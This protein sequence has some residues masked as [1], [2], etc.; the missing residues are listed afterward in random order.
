MSSK[1][2]LD[3]L[4]Q[5]GMLPDAVI[6]KL[7]R[8]LSE[9][10]KATTPDVVARMLVQ[11]GLLTVFQAK[12][13]L[14]EIQKQVGRKPAG[15]QPQPTKS[16]K[17]KKKA[18]ADSDDLGLAAI[19]DEPEASA[20]D[21]L[22]LAV[23]EEDLPEKTPASAETSA[24]GTP[25]ESGPAA[26]KAPQAPA[27]EG[28]T[29][30]DSGLTPLG[31]VDGLTPVAKRQ[32]RSEPAG[33]QPLDAL[34]DDPLL[35]ESEAE[36][37][38]SPLMGPEKPKAGLG[39]LLGRQKGEKPKRRKKSRENQWDSPLL[40]IG[41][42]AL[43]LLVLT[44]VLLTW[45]ALRTTGD[46]LFLAAED[47]YKA[48]AYTQA[49]GKYDKFIKKH[50]KHPKASTARVRRGLAR[51][52]YASEVNKNWVQALDTARKALPEIEAEADFAEA[53]PE[54]ASLL[55]NI[56]AGF[57]QLAQ[58][59]GDTEQAQKYVDLAGQ[60]MTLVD[61][62]AYL[63]TS[64]RK[65]RQ[66]RIDAIQADLALVVREINRDK[67]LQATIDAI[68]KAIEADDTPAAYQARK[69]LLG[70]YPSLAADASLREAVLE[71]S[72]KQREQVRPLDLPLGATLEDDRPTATTH[73][74]VFAP[75]R[76]G[77][78]AGV[79]NHRIFALAS[80]R[81][82]GIDA[83]TGSVLWRQYVGYRTSIRPIPLGSDAGRDVLVCDGRRDELLRLNA[84]TGEPVWRSAIGEPFLRP[85]IADEDVF[86]TTL[87]G[88][89]LAVDAASGEA[90]A[91]AA[92]PQAVRVGCAV[93]PRRPLLYQLADH[94]NLF[95]LSADT[96][97]CQDAFYLGH[98]PGGLTVP[99]VVARG[100]VLV[101][102]NAGAN[103]CMLHVA[104]LES[105]GS[106][107]VRPAEPIRLE[108]QVVTT[109]L[110][111]EGRVALI[112]TRGA[113]H[114]YEID[115][116]DTADPVRVA[117]ETL[118]TAEEDVVGYPLVD[119]GE[120]WVA[121]TQLTRYGLQLSRGQLAR[122]QAFLEGDAFV[123][124]LRVIG[125][126]LYCQR[127]RAGALGT[128]VAAIDL[129][130]DAGG[131]ILWETDLAVP[132]SVEVVENRISVQSAHGDVF[133]VGA[134]ALQ[135]RIVQ[136]PA[137]S[138]PNAGEQAAFPYRVALGDGRVSRIG[139][140]QRA[141]GV[142]CRF[143]NGETTAVPFSLMAIGA[144]AAAP[145][146]F[147]GGI[148]LPT[149]DGRIHLVDPADG[150]EMMMPFQPRRVP[151]AAITWRKPATLDG[152]GKRFIATDGAER[153]FLVGIEDNPRTHL[154]AVA[155]TALAAPLESDPATVGNTVYAAVRAGVG[156]ALVTYK[157][158]SLES[159]KE[160]A[161]DGAVV[162]GPVRLGDVVLLATQPGG[163]VCLGEGPELRW[164]AP[165][166][167]ANPVGE[168]ILLDG[169]LI[170]ALGDGTVLRLAP[171]SGEETARIDVGEPVDG[172]IVALGNR[173]LLSASDGSL[174]VAE[175]PK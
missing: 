164:K 106:T 143:N 145:A 146:A 46:E 59:A 76:G 84:T 69:D 126:V 10:E 26:T 5:R 75:R 173:L 73:R 90:R 117:A 128:T 66:A 111:F 62:S 52:R 141:G 166:S 61:N 116:A 2:F 35:A 42:G 32:T 65:G 93:D 53:R 7:R 72:R 123:A 121:D 171:D 115:P 142:T 163:L 87:S 31:G 1:L 135:S 118:G 40:L 140:S 68:R 172:R 58:E 134:D 78:A 64:L 6:A 129:A 127:R 119:R 50:S 23:L 144:P 165:L 86:V 60:A 168:P 152:D 54:L 30:L 99:P 51:M 15:E 102:D 11:R 98:R 124:P 36:A 55:P 97:E 95:V 27:V 138:I 155:Q 104:T 3:L 91:G 49:I 125:D 28:L 103:H 109:P 159:D 150:K 21:D 14:S 108:G 94:S 41:G 24:A 80:G 4:E 130:A 16:P 154:A 74:V 174:L 29:P 112:T 25:A 34:A 83:A 20:D 101:V 56:V 63:P 110:V 9:Q 82:Y 162:W 167:G 19:D 175:M 70:V 12:Q 85:V 44:G 158:P 71:I 131:M 22:G 157:L 89:V 17:P 88:K 107:L 122:K 100:F 137:A 120:L 45:L 114:V 57:A 147:A 136:R 160:F 133:S 113:I 169:Q 18:S 92:L 79:E 47:D 37:A 149:D 67:Q 38:P 105:G 139:R 43:L 81:V 170:V 153:M 161:L 156:H 48:Q 77:T 151:G 39:R 8:Q 13:L 132:G 33:L 148:L 96:L